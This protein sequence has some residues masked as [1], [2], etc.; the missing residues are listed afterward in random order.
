MDVVTYALYACVADGADAV[1]DAWEDTACCAQANC[2]HENI[3]K[4]YYA[5]NWGLHGI[6]HI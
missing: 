3:L 5:V 6:V 1:A 4:C 2:L